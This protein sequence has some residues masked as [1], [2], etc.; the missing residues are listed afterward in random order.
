[1]GASLKN[2]C[3]SKSVCC[4]RKCEQNVDEKPEKVGFASIL[5]PIF[6]KQRLF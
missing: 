1:M 2:F 5:V 4:N 3:Q 6:R